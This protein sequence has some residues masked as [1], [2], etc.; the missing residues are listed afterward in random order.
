MEKPKKV[1]ILTHGFMGDDW[2]RAHKEG[3]NKAIEQYDA[4]LVEKLIEISDELGLCSC[5]CQDSITKLIYE[6]K[7]E[8]GK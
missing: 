3:F 1:P 8:Y 6:I 4:W 2:D 5:A 7:G